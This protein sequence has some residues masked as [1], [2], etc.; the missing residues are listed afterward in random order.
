[1]TSANR[2]G[3][4]HSI[5]ACPAGTVCEADR[6]TAL[7][8]GSLRDP[9]WRRRMPVGCCRTEQKGTIIWTTRAVD[10]CRF[11][12]LTNITAQ[13]MTVPMSAEP[14]S[15]DQSTAL[16]EFARACKSAA[17]S[18]SMYPGTH[19]AIAVALSCVTLADKRFFTGGD[20]TLGVHPDVLVLVA[21][22]P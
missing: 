20:V 5:C 4:A 8:V 3:R 2:M 19:P 12:H 7:L 14:M 18:V 15:A 13:E 6:Q 21:L 16:A 17:R 22:V 9:T 10:V 1:M 11:E